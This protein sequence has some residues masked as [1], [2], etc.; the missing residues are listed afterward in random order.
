MHCGPAAPQHLRQ[1]HQHLHW[2]G[3]PHLPTHR[4]GRQNM[5]LGVSDGHL[6]LLLMTFI[7]IFHPSLP[8][9]LLPCPP[10]L[11]NPSPPF[12]LL[13]PLSCPTPPP[14][15]FSLPPAAPQCTPSWLQT[16]PQGHPGLYHVLQHEGGPICARTAHKIDADLP[17]GIK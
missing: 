17:N 3:P 4:P 14:S 9:L 7:H 1:H 15:P 12:S 13:S 5:Q 6:Y 8:L 16:P 10:L 2:T 11:S